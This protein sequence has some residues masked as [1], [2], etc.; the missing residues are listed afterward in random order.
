MSMITNIGVQL[1]YACS[2]AG[3]ELRVTQVAQSKLALKYHECYTDKDKAKV[4]DMDS[5]AKEDASK[6]CRMVKES[7]A[8]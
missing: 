7:P 1:N 8:Q 5:H 6:M 3:A 2:T 4:K